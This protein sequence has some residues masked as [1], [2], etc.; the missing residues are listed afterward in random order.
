MFDSLD[1]CS[2]DFR[3]VYVDSFT[4]FCKYTLFFQLIQL[5]DINRSP[6]DKTKRDLLVKLYNFLIS[7]LRFNSL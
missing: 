3:F 6:L 2:Y 4:L 1:R 7:L 5:S